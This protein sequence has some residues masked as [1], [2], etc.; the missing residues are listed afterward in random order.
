MNP[1]KILESPEAAKSAPLEL[2]WDALVDADFG[3]RNGFIP[4]DVLTTLESRVEFEGPSSSSPAFRI[5]ELIAAVAT[6]V[7][8]D[9]VGNYGKLELPLET[10][11]KESTPATHHTTS[12]P[13]FLDKA[14]VS[15]FSMSEG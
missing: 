10:S 15:L 3:G 2:V 8:Y 1:S 12:H 11:G 4:L 13:S 9:K 7:G 5:E 14:P 6:K